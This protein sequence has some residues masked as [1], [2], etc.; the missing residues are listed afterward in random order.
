MSF[1]FLDYL[2][3]LPN[4]TSGIDEI[5]K[6]TINAVPQLATFLLVFLWFV[7]FLGGVIR[8]NL[9]TGSADYAAWSVAAS[10]ST[11]MAVLIMSVSSGFIKLDYLIVVVVI[12]IFS[13]VWLALDKRGNEM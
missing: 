7:V 1:I 12:T 9:R 8:Q 10:L 6:Q 2:Y 4:A 5:A 11:F 13:F 3:E